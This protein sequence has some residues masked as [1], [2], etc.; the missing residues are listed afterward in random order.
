MKEQVMIHRADTAEE[1]SRQC[2]RWLHI[3][4]N[5]GVLVSPFISREEK[6]IL[7]RAEEAGGKI[8]IISNRYMG[9]RFKPSGHEFELC[10]Q[11]R[12]LILAPLE[13]TGELTRSACLRMNF[14]AAETAAFVRP[15]KAESGDR[16]QE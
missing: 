4:A 10:E 14:F 16:G 8:I 7:K 9:E 1:K 2:D 12:L 6:E 13:L 11:G 3:A 15:L 5:G